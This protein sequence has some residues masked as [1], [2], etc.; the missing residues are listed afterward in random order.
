MK[1]KTLLTAI[2][3]IFST[4]L[5]AQII[6]VPTD[7]PTIQD[8][9]FAA[10][11]GDTVV[12]EEGTYIENISFWGKAITVAS[13]FIL[14]RDTEHISNTIID[15]SEP[16]DPN[17][18]SVVTFE[19]GEDTSS[20]IMGFTIT[21][22]SGTVDI[23]VI[24]ITVGAGILCYNSGA[25]IINNYIEN[26]N[27]ETFYYAE[28]AGIST[29]PP[30]LNFYVII[31]NNKVSNNNI[32]S[33][34]ASNG[35][36]IGIRSNGLVSGNE[37]FD[38][39]VES[40]SEYAVGGGIFCGGF[41]QDVN[42]EIH[43]NNIYENSVFSL[44]TVD[45]G[46]SAGGL[47]I[48]KN[49]GSVSHNKIT[50]NYIEGGGIQRGAGVV[51]SSVDAS[52]V[53][54]NNLVAY[55]QCG[56]EEDDECWGGLQVHFGS[57]VLL[58]NVIY[59]NEVSFGGGIFIYSF[60]EDPV[61]IINNT[62]TENYAEMSAGGI[63]IHEADV[64]IMNTIF[65][66]NSSPGVQE[67][68]D[69]DSDLEVVYS[70]ID[71]GWEGEGNID[72]NPDFEDDTLFHITDGSAC[73]NS[74]TESFELNGSVY[75]C[76]SFDYE[77]DPRPS[78]GGYDIGADEIFFVGL[79]ELRVTG[80]E[81]R[82][83]PVPCTSIVHLRISNIE[84]GYVNLEIFTIEGVRIKRLLKEVKMPGGYEIEVDLSDLPTG[85]YFVRLQAGDDIETAKIIVTN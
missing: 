67:I 27:I 34:A 38:N 76:P 47:M 15:G 20:V 78:D 71:G 35:G 29:G 28:G 79:N 54:E 24:N 21:G 32:T 14:D 7:H 82:V 39:T 56:V 72:E 36:G 64:L 44:S 70:N 16:E 57:P 42:V 85:V 30:D 1:T 62:I 26:N 52:L 19:S 60:L 23:S 50:A 84:Q 8:G 17:Y 18:G 13:R 11:D 40:L 3:L 73:Q 33:N 55:N 58:N 74:A 81:L 66:D 37:I 41:E 53:F 83:F 22:G 9:I 80:C 77:D 31:K 10:A 5:S 59:H 12:V 61:Q 46:S 65:W 75:Y 45:V 4:I 48:Y 25:T 69:W 68:S 49:N 43:N 6:W 63:Y 51:I 2:I